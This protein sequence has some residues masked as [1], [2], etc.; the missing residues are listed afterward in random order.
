MRLVQQ[1]FFLFTKYP[2]VSLHGLKVNMY[3]IIPENLKF[4]IKCCINA[5]LNSKNTHNVANFQQF[6]KFS[7]LS[8]NSILSLLENP[9]FSNFSSII[10]YGM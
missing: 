5:S 1:E 10:S 4:F 3:I 7:N 9:C 8:M 6:G 2:V